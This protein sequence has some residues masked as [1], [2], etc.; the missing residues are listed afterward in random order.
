[1][2]NVLNL[3]GSCL[4]LPTLALI[5]EMLERSGEVVV[6]GCAVA[7]DAPFARILGYEVFREERDGY[8]HTSIEHIKPP[9]TAHQFSTPVGV[10]P[11]AHCGT[12]NDTPAGRVLD[13]T[14]CARC[15]N[16]RE[17]PK[18]TPE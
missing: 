6:K 11:C 7:S 16:T 18:G 10:P 13:S 2:S 4:T 9:F 12:T 3:N 5:A 1:M 14:L 8:W 15:Y 17:T